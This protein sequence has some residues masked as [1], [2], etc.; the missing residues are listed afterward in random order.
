[1]GEE[2]ERG[3]KFDAIKEDHEAFND[4]LNEGAKNFQN[5]HLLLT[6]IYI[7]NKYPVRAR[8]LSLYNYAAVTI[9]PVLKKHDGIVTEHK[10]LKL[11]LKSSLCLL[12]SNQVI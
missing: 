11:V 1:M 7:W 2:R 9:F 6:C 8:F 12:L 10:I 4:P 5:H 3:R